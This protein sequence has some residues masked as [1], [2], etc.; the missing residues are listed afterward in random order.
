MRYYKVATDGDRKRGDN[1]MNKVGARLKKLRGDR[2]RKELADALGLK[3]STI[4]MYENG[5]RIPRDKM[6]IKM[7]K[8]FN[9][10]VKTLFF[11]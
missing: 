1:R 8:Y 11:D 10:D 5:Q 9:T 7:A 3:V 4:G 2:S 6:K